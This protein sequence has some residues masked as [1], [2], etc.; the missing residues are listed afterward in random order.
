MSKE[1]E[2]NTALYN[3]RRNYPNYISSFGSCSTEGCSNSARGSG[4]CAVCCE[5]E[6]ADIIGNKELAHKIHEHTREVAH[7]IDNALT[8]IGEL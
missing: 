2:F 6:I 5:N 7:S 3:L 8:L 1:A 4:K